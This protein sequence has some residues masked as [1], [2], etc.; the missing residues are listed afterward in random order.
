MENVNVSNEN[1]ECVPEESE[2]IIDQETVDVLKKKEDTQDPISTVDNNK[3]DD[4]VVPSTTPKQ[5]EEQEN[6][7]EIDTNISTTIVPDRANVPFQELNESEKQEENETLANSSE[8]PISRK[9]DLD[10]EDEQIQ[11]N[12]LN[13]D[14]QTKRIKIS[15]STDIPTIETKEPDVTVEV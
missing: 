7:N 5:I 3:D 14:D 4:E 15:E 9:R 11:D 13:H 2:K 6:G 1:E 12:I 8:V 10:H